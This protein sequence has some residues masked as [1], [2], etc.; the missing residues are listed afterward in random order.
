MSDSEK[1]AVLAARV[2]KSFCDVQFARNQGSVDDM[3]GCNRCVLL[4]LCE[5]NS[6]H[7]FDAGLMPKV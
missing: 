3:A 6:I 7:T 4:P 5:E 2:L 1:R